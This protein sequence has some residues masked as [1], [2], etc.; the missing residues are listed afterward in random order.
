VSSERSAFAAEPDAS[1]AGRNAASPS[2]RRAQVDPPLYGIAMSSVEFY[3]A[4]QTD[5]P[6]ADTRL[7][8][9][10]DLILAARAET[11]LD[12]GCGRGTLGAM[13]LAQ[14]PNMRIYGTE[15]TPASI[16][17]ATQ[18]GIT[19]VTKDV[20]TG[21]SL[22]DESVDVV[23]MGEIIEHL[24]DPD[25]VVDE[26][27][28]VLRPGGQLIVTT[29][30]IAS[31][32]NRLVLALGI[33]PLFTETS[34]RKKYGR[35]FRFL[36][37]GSTV[38][39]GHLRLFTLSALTEM[40]EDLGFA[41]IKTRGADVSMFDVFPPAGWVDRICARFPRFASDLIVVARKNSPPA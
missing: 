25:A 2:E 26:V 19:I 37:Q 34:T 10:L 32:T 18:V 11:L 29:P 22:P 33:Q 41:I 15:L 3:S 12:I 23:V 4:R 7:R 5:H 13:I 30:N 20:T 21:I 14:R 39:Q 6:V 17:E 36:G 24:V 8:I 1:Y 16:E 38:M 9:V 35:R 40:L 27:H 31:W 28:R